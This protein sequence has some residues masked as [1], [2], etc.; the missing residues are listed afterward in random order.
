MHVRPD[1]THNDRPAVV[2]TLRCDEARQL[3]HMF[4]GSV[5]QKSPTPSPGQPH[6]P[7]RHH[8][9]RRHERPSTP[10][11]MMAMLVLTSLVEWWRGRP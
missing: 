4:A 9:G 6:Q 3:A 7:S 11:S 1:R 8:S 10:S 2:L 5:H